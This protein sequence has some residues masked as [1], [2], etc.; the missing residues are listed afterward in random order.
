MILVAPAE[1]REAAE[2][3][4]RNGIHQTLL[5]QADQP[6]GSAEQPCCTEAQAAADHHIGDPL[7]NLLQ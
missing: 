3:D 6:I 5:K 2:R 7:A 4:R 1:M